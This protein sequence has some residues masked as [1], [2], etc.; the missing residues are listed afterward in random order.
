MPFDCYSGVSVLSFPGMTAEWKRFN[1]ASLVTHEVL[2]QWMGNLVSAGWWS[3]IWIHEGLTPFETLVNFRAISRTLYLLFWILGFAEYFSDLALA[4]D[5]PEFQAE[6]TFINS[7]S[8]IAFR[9]DQSSR[10]HPV[11]HN[12]TLTRRRG[13]KT[14]ESEDAVDDTVY[15]KGASLV[16]MMRFVMTEPVFK[17]GIRAFFKKL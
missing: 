5:S 10:A 12:F 11:K 2:H 17:D 9:F 8:Q 1:M 7:H 16:R 3:D 6:I 15:S 14:D 13:G 4:H